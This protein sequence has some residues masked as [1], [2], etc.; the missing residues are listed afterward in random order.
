MTRYN[1]IRV[2]ELSD[3]FL[4]GEYHEAGRILKKEYCTLGD[5]YD[6]RLGKGHVKWAKKHTLFVVKRYKQLCDEMLFRGFKVNYPAD[7]FEKFAKENTCFID[8]N[9]YEVK[10]CD[11]QLNRARLIERYRANPKIHKWTKRTKPEWLN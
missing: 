8:W 7:E 6:Y 3:P 2:E 5:L 4:M 10:D 11:I 9:D 1:V